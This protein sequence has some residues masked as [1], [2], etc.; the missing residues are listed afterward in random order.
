MWV[1]GCRNF[2][3]ANQEM[4]NSVEAYHSLLKSKFLYDRRKKCA[5]RMG[6]LLYMLLI[7][8][9]LYYR[10]KD[11]LKEEGYLNN[12]KKEKLF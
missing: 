7:H 8:V 10:F 6:W 1:K 2:R 11:I 5:R 4:N 12:H 9:E 3:H